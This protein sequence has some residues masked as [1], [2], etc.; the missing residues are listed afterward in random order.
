MR[1]TEYD[2]DEMLMSES[3]PTINV[4]SINSKCLSARSSSPFLVGLERILEDEQKRQHERLQVLKEKQKHIGEKVA[5][6]LNDKE[7]KIKQLENEQRK[8]LYAECTFKPNTAFT[9]PAKKG[10]TKRSFDEFLHQQKE[11]TNKVAQK[12]H[13]LKE[14]LDAKKNEETYHPKIKGK[15]EKRSRNVPVYERL[16]A[17]KDKE[18]DDYNQQERLPEFKPTITEKSKRM[19]RKAPI[20]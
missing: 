7:R 4:P 16:Y 10:Q 2:Y 13:A 1:H 8:K 15:S 17:L 18:N 9:K 3:V 19:A 6:R 12:R 11:F 5:R 14:S 20:D